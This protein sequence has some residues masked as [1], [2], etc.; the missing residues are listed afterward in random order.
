MEK[1]SNQLKLYAFIRSYYFYLYFILLIILIFLKI[2]DLQ[3][4]YIEI[5]HLTNIIFIFIKTIN[6]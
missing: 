5:F 2:I 3:I 4:V 6:R 1:L